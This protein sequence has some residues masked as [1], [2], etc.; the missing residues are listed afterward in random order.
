LV[1]KGV[2]QGAVFQMRQRLGNCASQACR[3]VALGLEQRKRKALR[4]LW[5]HARQHT[6]RIY[7]VLNSVLSHVTFIVDVKA[8]S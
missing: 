1:G 6:K 5:P 2:T 8:K 4:R 3:P 7:Q